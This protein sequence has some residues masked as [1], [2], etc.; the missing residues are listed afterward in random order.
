MVGDVAQNAEP[1]LCSAKPHFRH[2][3]P[4]LLHW[5]LLLYI[6]GGQFCSMQS[7]AAVVLHCIAV[8]LAV[9]CDG[10][11]HRDTREGETA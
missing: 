3:L 1:A 8:L 4:Q 7:S 2:M 10:M 11:A 9:S 6:L 5:P